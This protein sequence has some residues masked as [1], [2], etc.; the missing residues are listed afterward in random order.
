MRIVN[1]P[2]DDKFMD[3]AVA[4]NADFLVT[5]DRHFNVLAQT[6]FPLVNAIKAEA[7]LGILTANQRRV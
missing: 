3:L 4:G 1:D 2:D 6:T 7:F 5:N